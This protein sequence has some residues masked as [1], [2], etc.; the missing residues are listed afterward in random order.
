MRN[1]RL[2]ICVENFA[3]KICV[4]NF[5][6]ET[7]V[8]IVVSQAILNSAQM[9]IIL[10]VLLEAHLRYSKQIHYGKIFTLETATQNSP[11]KIRHPKF[12]TQNSGRKLRKI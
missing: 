10:P 8:E 12:A 5:A 2:E 6:S 4:P 3:T 7:L 11:R 1:M 9:I